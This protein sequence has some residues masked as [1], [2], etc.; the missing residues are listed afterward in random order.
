MS[1]SEGSGSKLLGE[2]LFILDLERFFIGYG[3]GVISY[4]V[5]IYIAEIAPKNLHGGLATT[6]QLLIVKVGHEKEFQ[7]ALRRLTDKDAD[8]SHEAQ[9]MA[10]R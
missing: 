8:I 3:I 6:N 1:R 4:V 7:L 9:E 10:K 2:G 5:L